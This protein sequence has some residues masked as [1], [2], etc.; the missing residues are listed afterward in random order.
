MARTWTP[1]QLVAYNLRRAR[2]L[3][4]WTQE[5]AAEVIARYL[6]EK[7]SVAT[8]SAAERSVRGDRIRQFSADE[9][10][11]FGKAF[12]LPLSYFLTPTATRSVKAAEKARTIKPPEMLDVVY[13][14]PRGMEETSKRVKELFDAIGEENL[15]DT[16]RNAFATFNEVLGYGMVRE[17]NNV[18]EWIYDLRHL[19]QLADVLEKVRDKWPN[20]RKDKEA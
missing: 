6:G 3:R 18:E 11:A 4:G 2:E 20:A 1:N 12:D 19:Q 8:F 10:V 15:T 5:Q 7:W 14:T 9:L 16:Q 17:L 13:G